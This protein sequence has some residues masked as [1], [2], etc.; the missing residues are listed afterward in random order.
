M[1]GRE[2][3]TGGG[4]RQKNEMEEKRP[5]KL[6]VWKFAKRG[7]RRGRQGSLKKDNFEKNVR[8]EGKKRKP[9]LFWERIWIDDADLS[10]AKRKPARENKV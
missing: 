10:E 7:W 9:S 1:N 4:V 3:L 8:R 2:I 5:I 6:L